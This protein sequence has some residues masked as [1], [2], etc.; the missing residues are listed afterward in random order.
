MRAALNH[1]LNLRPEMDVVVVGDIN[2]DTDWIPALEGIN[3][4]VH[5]A[6]R[7]H[8]MD[9]DSIDPLKE[10]R[11]V[12]TLGTER[13]ARMASAAGVNRF[14][15]VSSIKVNG[16][17]TGQN[18]SGKNQYF[19]ENDVP[20]P[21]DAYALSKWQAEEGLQGIASETGMDLVVVRPPL[22]YGPGVKANFFRL[23][24][25]VDQGIRLPLASVENSRSLIALE[26]LVDFLQRCVEHPSAAGEK[27]LVSD[28][29][30]LSTPELIRRI[31]HHMK[32][33]VRL[34]P[35][36]PGILRLG[37]HLL[38]KG[39]LTDRLLGS[40]QVDIGKAKRILGWEPPVSID[41]ALEKTVAWYLTSEKLQHG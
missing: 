3:A 35:F 37:G 33:P 40:L 16:E 15:Y 38:K 2:Q 9:D 27:F 14:V 13:L 28:G 22:V 12:N 32:R 6:A 36:P 7:V 10:F 29:E 30:D 26:N 4:V 17:S 31:A 5:L 1:R 20:H 8:I 19:S 41:N 11:K 39:D 21:Q 24:K 25:M 23:L 18:A 34:V